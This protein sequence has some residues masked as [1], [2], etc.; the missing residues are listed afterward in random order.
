M[1]RGQKVEN[2]GILIEKWKLIFIV[3]RKYKIKKY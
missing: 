2:R 1:W 3:K